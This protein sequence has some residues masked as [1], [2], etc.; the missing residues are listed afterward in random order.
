MPDLIAH[1]GAVGDGIADDTTALRNALASGLPIEAPEAVYKITGTISLPAGADLAGRGRPTFKFVG[2]MSGGLF[3]T[4]GDGVMVRDIIIDGDKTSK[5]FGTV[6]GL[7]LGHAGAVVENV[8]VRECKTRGMYITGN[9]NRIHGGSVTGTSGPATQVIGGWGNILS[10]IDLSG[11]AGFGCHLDGGAHDNKLNGLQCFGNGLE[12]LGA[13]Y[14]TYR[15]RISDCHAEATG[16]NGFSLTGF[17]NT[18]MGCVALRCKHSGIYLYGSRNTVSN[19][20]SKDN[21]QRFLI[22]GSKW[23]GMMVVPGWG[24][25]GS[26][27]VVTGNEFIDTQSIATQAYGIR[28]GRHAY[29]LWAASRSTNAGAYVASGAN[30][31]KATTAGTTGATPPTHTSGTASDGG[32]SW[33]WI[34][35]TTTNLDA[36]NNI[37]AANVVRGNWSADVSVTS[38]NLQRVETFDWVTGRPLWVR[39]TGIFDAMGNA[40]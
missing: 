29:T 13:T 25:L 24:G 35:G 4:A 39:S 10:D 11:N 5:G 38:P 1:F 32:V 31:Y 15:N 36:A 18:L 40:A 16:D 14:S 8:R 33:A 2:P 34:T 12:L 22:D 17:E 19:N 6:W 7:G 27:N 20:M 37:L 26:D 30:V 28:V 9:G 3:A 23:A 21:G